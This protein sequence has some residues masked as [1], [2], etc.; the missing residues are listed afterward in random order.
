MIHL[1]PSRIGR[2]IVLLCLFAVLSATAQAGREV[3]DFTLTDLSGHSHQLHRTGGR[4]VVLFFT[5]TGCPI[6]RKSIPKLKAIEDRFG[7]EGVST[8]IIN[9]YPEDTRRDILKEVD[10][11]GLRRATYLRDPIQGVALALG[12]QRTAEVAVIS[13]ADWKVVYQGSIDDQ[14]SEGAELPEPRQKFLETALTE[15]LSGRPVTRARTTSHGCRLA[16]AGTGGEIP[17]YSRDVAPLLQKSCVSCH[18]DGAL[19]PWAMDGHARVKNN[20]AMIEEV[21]LMHRMPPWSADP[22]FGHFSNDPRLTRD[23]TQTLLRWVAAGAP[24]GEGLD[25]L[26]EPLPPLGEWALGKPDVVIRLPEMQHVPATGVLDYRQ[27]PIPSPFTNG[28]WIAGME[29]KPGNRKVVHHAILYA[30]WPGCPDGGT[31]KGVHLYGWAPGTPS[32]RYPDGV[33]KYLPAGA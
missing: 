7:P 10:E 26:T 6:A 18:R 31:G 5:G 11:L 2:P 22:D 28:V 25:P 15:F 32:L 23:E 17:S 30:K 1:N 16:Y 13:T 21:L 29:V 33:G 4:A 24:R 9:A 12:V 20:A 19:A 8:W 27:I 14:L 3:P